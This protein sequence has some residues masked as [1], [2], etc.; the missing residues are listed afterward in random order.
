M[1]NLNLFEIVDS[2]W[3][4]V[5]FT[6][7]EDFNKIG[8]D[9]Q[10]AQLARSVFGVHRQDFVR[11]ARRLPTGH[12]EFAPR[13]FGHC[14]EG[15]MI[16][17]AAHVPS[18]IPVLQPP[19][20]DLIQSGSRNDAEL[21]KLRYGLGKLPTGYSGAHTTLNDRRKVTHTSEYGPPSPF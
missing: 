1:R 9:A 20:E 2:D 15:E 13:A 16:E 18:R 4:A 17:A 11:R 21:A 6:S 7:E 10:L 19:G 12:I 3:I 14:G 8:E 5:T